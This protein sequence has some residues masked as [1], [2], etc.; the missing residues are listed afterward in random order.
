MPDRYDPSLLPAIAEINETWTLHRPC[1]LWDF[2][3]YRGDMQ[4][5]YAFAALFIPDVVEV[6]G[7]VILAEQFTPES[8][9]SWRSRFDGDLGAV[10]RMM[11]HVH[12]SDLFL[13]GT[14]NS[15]LPEAVAQRIGEALRVG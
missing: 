8:F 2:V 12:I 15:V 1:S 11:N 9:E 10:E 7:A 4:L 5:G 13:N 6:D 3:N 14:N